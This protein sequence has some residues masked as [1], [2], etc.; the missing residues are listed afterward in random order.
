MMNNRNP[1]FTIPYEFLSE[2]EE[3]KLIK[4]YLDKFNKILEKGYERE[5]LLNNHRIGK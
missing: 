1:K 4:D 5:I 2:E 3:R